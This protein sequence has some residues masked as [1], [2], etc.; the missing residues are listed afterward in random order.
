MSKRTRKTI[1][2]ILMMGAGFFINE[3]LDEYTLVA[4]AIEK[5]LVRQ[6]LNTK[7]SKEV[8]KPAETTEESDP[9]SCSPCS[10]CLIK[11]GAISRLLDEREI[12]HYDEDGRELDTYDRIAILA[13]ASALEEELN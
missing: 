5:E 7:K 13:A 9:L 6:G 2:K 10:N 3:C 8:E 4:Q 1:T 12:P 11:I